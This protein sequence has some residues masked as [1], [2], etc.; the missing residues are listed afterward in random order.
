MMKTS[1]KG[2]EF[3]KK[4]EGLRLK[5]Y[6]L[7][8]ETYYSIGYAHSYDPSI[9]ANTIWTNAQAEAALRVDLQK[10]EKYVE[11]N[12]TIPL[13][14]SRFDALVSYCYNRGLGGLKE[15]VS[16]SKTIEDYS[17]NIVKYWGSATRYKDALIKRRKAEKELFDSVDI[18]YPTLKKGAK[19]DAVRLLQHK[20]NLV[21]YNL[22]ED[23]IFG[24]STLKAVKEYQ[25]ANGL[26]PDG[27]VGQKTWSKVVDI[28]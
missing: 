14:Q 10:F 18:N 24:D 5:A 2:I 3:L 13:T 12:V 25:T 8:G 17:K 28:K 21:G 15:L 9:T 1:D 26:S 23:G 4:H 19:N 27:I 20:L 11:Q 6:K 16:H 22:A 7:E